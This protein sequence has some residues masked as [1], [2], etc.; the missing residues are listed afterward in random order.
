MHGALAR[1]VT[2]GDPGWESFGEQRSP[3]MIFAEPAEVRENPLEPER[4]AWGR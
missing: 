2:D 1:F 3:V 4:A